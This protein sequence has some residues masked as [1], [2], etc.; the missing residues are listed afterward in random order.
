[1]AEIVEKI[2]FDLARPIIF[3]NSVKLSLVLLIET[4]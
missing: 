1:M 3:I 2:I 4:A